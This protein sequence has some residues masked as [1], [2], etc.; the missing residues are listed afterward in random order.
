VFSS[1]DP[2]RDPRPKT[3]EDLTAEIQALHARLWEAEETL[4]AIGDGEVDALVIRERRGEKVY[5]LKSADRVYRLMIEGMSQGALTL[6]AEGRILYSNTGFSQLLKLPLDSVLDNALEDF[7]APEHRGLLEASL[8]QAWVAGRSQEEIAL[9]AADGTR[10]P[11][12]LAFNTHAL[13]DGV[14]SLH[15]VVTDLTETKRIDELLASEGEA[16]AANVAKDQ[17]L[18]NLSHELRTPLAPVMAVVSRLEGDPRLPGDVQESLAMVRRNVELE[19]RLIDDLLDL[20]RVARGKLALE[21]RVTDLREVVQQ[22]IETCC[23]SAIA[24]GRLRIVQDLEAEDHRLWADPSRMAQVLWNL[25][26]NAVK[27]T[28]EGGTV[29]IRS[30]T[31]T[32]PETPGGLVLCVQ[33]ADTGIGIREDLLPRIFSAFDQGEQGTARRFGGLGLG[34]TISRAIVEAHGGRLT[35]ASE[36]SG[37]GAV[38][39]LRLPVCPDL[40]EA[41]GTGPLH[42]GEAESTGGP[43]PELHILLVEDHAD[44]AQA[45]A[46]LLNALGHRVTLAGS[47]AEA[48][49]AAEHAPPIDLVVSDLGLP[50]GNGQDL[51]RELI[52]RHGLRGIAL[53][54]Y[55]MEQDLRKSREAGFERHLI[56]P[57]DAEVFKAAIRQVARR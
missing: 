37:R 10:V 27:F 40:G 11:V 34:L 17:F 23:S 13:E 7:V 5:T 56:K 4:R 2:A 22:A 46:A 38:F 52:R 24:A 57:V 20:T 50:D 16:R 41:A 47:I 30:W 36:G 44:T 1:D 28:P 54:G 33:V 14:I 29:S 45:M 19:A 3:L 18:A 25:L 8:R 42:R 31:E 32:S 6:T 15:L 49:I 39:T 48:L 53:S 35:A 43:E 12:S 55:G 26:N 9:V 51:M 21:R